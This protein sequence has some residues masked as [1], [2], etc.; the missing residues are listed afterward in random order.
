LVH[1]LL[2]LSRISLGKIALYRECI[3]ISAIVSQALETSRPNIDANGHELTVS[4]PG[5]PL[6]VDGDLTRLSQVIANLLNNAAKYTRRGGHISLSAEHN[7][8]HGD[9]TPSGE[10][11]EGEVVLRVRD[12]GIGIPE[13][14]LS[15]IFN[16]FTQVDTSLERKTA[17]LGI[18]LTLARQLIELHGGS[19]EAHSAGV[20]QGSE[21]VVRLPLA[22]PQAAPPAEAATDS[23][24][25]TQTKQ[26]ARRILVVDDNKDAAESFAK[27]LELAGHEVRMAH[28]GL[29]AV[30]L[31]GA[32][33]PDVVLLD[34][35]LPKLNGLDAAR[36]IRQ[37]PWGKDM[38]LVA[39]TGWG[40]EEDQQRS[41]EAGFDHHLVKPVKAATLSDLLAGVPS[42][43]ARNS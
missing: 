39:L 37:Q 2:D 34:I 40:Q 28:D 26:P 29:E 31:A 21:F 33:R 25:H 14:M 19:I 17:G 12:N 3:P 27:L 6:F 32:F 30:N 9:G 13:E 16:M 38:T 41:K 43:A 4:L 8:T 42:S 35:G 10:G 22:K 5:E 7:A 11:G 20:G 1:D 18:G 15:N 23:Q 36:H 24:P